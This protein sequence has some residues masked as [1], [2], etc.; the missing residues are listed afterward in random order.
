MKKIIAI[1]LCIIVLVTTVLAL[2][3][4]SPRIEKKVNPL[5]GFELVEKQVASKVER[6][7]V[8]LCDP[9]E[10]EYSFSDKLEN[11]K[12]LD[13]YTDNAGNDF[14]KNSDGTLRAAFIDKNAPSRISDK[15]SDATVLL[16]EDECRKIAVTAVEKTVG[17]ASDYKETFSKVTGKGSDSFY[18]FTFSEM[19]GGYKTEN[20]IKLSINALG[21]VFAYSFVNDYDY[22]KL[23]LGVLSEITD[24]VLND[25]VKN[26]L[27]IDYKSYEIIDT[28]LSQDDGTYSIKIVL[29]VEVPVSDRGTVSNYYEI[30]Y[31][32]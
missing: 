28:Y 10:A 1:F 23:N 25:Y 21:E 31:K 26:N 7:N 3:A 19:I 15:I 14:V 5:N 16:S 12:V 32:I 4:W 8:P 6:F 29:S 24:S 18:T 11:G 2:S 20:A 17:K 9:I 22:S 13:H 30:H 27:T